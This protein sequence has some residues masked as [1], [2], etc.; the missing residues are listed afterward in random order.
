VRQHGKT[1]L[2]SGHAQ[3]PKGIPKREYLQ[4]TTALL[5]VDIEKQ[6]I[7]RAEFITVLPLTNDFL[8]DLA[9]GYDL[10]QG[11]GPLVREMEER[12][13]ISSIRAFIKAVEIAYQRYE[14]FRKAKK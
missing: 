1:Y 5:E 2:F 7:V 9:E 6:V 4:R 8:A 12:S 13:H 11:I 10:H 14:E 3:L